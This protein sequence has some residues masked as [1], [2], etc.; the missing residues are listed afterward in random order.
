MFFNLFPINLYCTNF[1]FSIS[2]KDVFA[3]KETF[4]P[5]PCFFSENQYNKKEQLMICKLKIVV[6][7]CSINTVKIRNQYEETKVF[8]YIIFDGFSVFQEIKE[9]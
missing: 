3:K 1:F 8:T 9:V 2:I 7:K 4:L 5:E 6:H